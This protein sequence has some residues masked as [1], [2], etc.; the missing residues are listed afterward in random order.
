MA[1]AYGSISNSGWQISGSAVVTKPTGLAVGDIMLAFC[2][3]NADGFAF[4]SGFTSIGSTSAGGNNYQTR[5]GYKV[6]DSS[7]VSATNFT[8]TI[9]TSSTN[10]CVLI[11]ITGS[12]SSSTTIKSSGTLVSNSATPSITGITPYARGDILLFQLWH[13]SDA[14]TAVSSYA[15]ATSNPTWTEILDTTA[16]GGNAGC[17]IAYAKRSQLTATGNFSAAGGNAS[18]DWGGWIISFS[19]SLDFSVAE[20]LTVTE[21]HKQNQ[22]I[23]KSESVTLTDEEDIE[24]E[25]WR[26]INKN[27]STWNNIDKS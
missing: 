22:S 15:I 9:G 8:F 27:V 2:A 18:T 7:D 16:A 24:I 26:N 17:G 19:P 6:A 14:V 21:N 5:L 20:S 25:K 12:S 1:V 11:R 4:P 3:G 23:K 13:G 10:I